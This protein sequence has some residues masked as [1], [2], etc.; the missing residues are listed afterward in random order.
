M[1]TL[2]SVSSKELKDEK[3][4]RVEVEE[5]QNGFLIVRNTEW[6]DKKGYHYDTKKYFSETNPLDDSVKSLVDSF[7]D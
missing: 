1:G 3:K 2:K 6:E 4:T 7:K 5:I